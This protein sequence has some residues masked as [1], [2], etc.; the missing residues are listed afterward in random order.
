[1]HYFGEPSFPP[2]LR[3]PRAPSKVKSWLSKTPVWIE[4]RAVKIPQ[5]EALPEL[6]RGERDAILL[7]QET[8]ADILLIDE[9]QGR[10]EARRRGITTTGKLGVLLAAGARGLLDAK[11]SFERLMSDTTFRATPELQQHFVAQC[12]KL[13]Q[14]K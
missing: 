14:R 8:H 3:H 7:A 4:V 2:Q 9:K 5:E 11:A 10:A 12:E 6:D 1:M 13:K